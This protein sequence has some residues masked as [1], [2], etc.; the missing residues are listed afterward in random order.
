MQTPTYAEE[1]VLAGLML[2]NDHFH[3]IA[4]G[5]N[6]DQFTS[7]QRRRIWEAVR[8]RILAGEP[9]DVTTLAESLPDDA[10]E[11]FD[12]YS[13]AAGAVNVRAYAKIIRENWRRREAALIAGRLLAGSREGSDSAV[14]EAIGSL[15]ALTATVTECDW[16]LKQA[17]Q[18][19]YQQM[20]AAHENGG[21]L[22]GITTGI[23]ALDE[24]LG[25][26]HDADLILIG[27]RPAMGKTALMMN[28]AE[29]AAKT[30][31]IVG[32]VSAEQPAVQIGLRTIA[33]GSRVGAADMRRGRIDEDAWAKIGASVKAAADWRMRVYDRS[34]ITLDELVSVARKWK[35]AHGLD[36]LFIDYAQRITVP[37]AD[38]ITEVSTIARG[39]KNLARD[40]N[41]PVVALAQ[42]K[43]AVD[44]RNDRRPQSGDLA[45]SDELTREADGI[46]MLY[47]EEAYYHD[48]N[49]Q[50]KP[51]R[52]G[53]AE[54]LIE[55]NRHGPT[56]YVECAFLAETMR[57]G[58][59]EKYA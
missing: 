2:D 22:P 25:G 58:N 30:G 15:L 55:K 21:A 34:A 14:D 47:R 27:A 56:G 50:G 48:N 24:I 42:V 1:A 45:N 54:I 31:K 53:V 23:T 49:E 11:I 41:I 13:Q 43:A 8:E 39:L 32:V 18:Q 40:L 9:A 10:G 12:I 52:K 16:T 17:M 20:L 33:L 6:A 44:A 37:G 19:A 46:L 29:S 28:L 7:P 5:C 36:V 51:V 57:F 3:A 4:S 59:L 26:L 35:H 38:R